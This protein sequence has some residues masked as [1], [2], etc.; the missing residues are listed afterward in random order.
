MKTLLVYLLLVLFFISSIKSQQ[1][2]EVASLAKFIDF[3]A[4]NYTGII[5]EAIPLY[6]VSV[7]DF[8]MPI[9]LEY[10]ARGI[11]VDEI[12]S[13]VGQGW[14]LNAGGV[15]TR[16]MRGLPDDFNK[17]HRYYRFNIGD[18]YPRIGMFWHAKSE[19]I[20]NFDVSL[21]SGECK[22][23]FTYSLCDILCPYNLEPHYGDSMD[24]EIMLGENDTEY[25]IFYINCNG[26]QG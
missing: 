18:N 16:A 3:P 15:I 17:E 6:E 14:N 7:K 9:S 19:K 1:T 22:Y 20:K 24:Y 11:Q 25:D 5:S 12:A 21:V 4:A 2:P 26:I 8:S 13:N 23:D 10:H